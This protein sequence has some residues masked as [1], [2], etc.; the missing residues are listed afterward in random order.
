MYVLY[1]AV[2]TGERCVGV[3][4]DKLELNESDLYYIYYIYIICMISELYV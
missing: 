2:M 4:K 3:A 1:I